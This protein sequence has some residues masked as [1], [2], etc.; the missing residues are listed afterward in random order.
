[1]LTAFLPTASSYSGF[2]QPKHF[3]K[4]LKT[5]PKNVKLVIV[6]HFLYQSHF[7]NPI[8]FEN[9]DIVEKLL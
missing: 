7:K 5:L 8:D 6:E 2:P 1:M 3:T 9:L 4:I